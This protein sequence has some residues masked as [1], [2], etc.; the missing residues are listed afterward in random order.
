[1][2]YK[3]EGKNLM[4]YKGGRWKVK[5]H[6]TSHENAIKAMKLLR[7]LERGTIKKEDVK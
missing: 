4:H 3:V 1:M 5:Q 6:C 2:P 7:G